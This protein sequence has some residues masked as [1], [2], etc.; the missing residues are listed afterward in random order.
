MNTCYN[1][2]IKKSTAC[3][4]AGTQDFPNISADQ[5]FQ[6][7]IYANIF[8]V[9]FE[10]TQNRIYAGAQDAWGKGCANPLVRSVT[11]VIIIIMVIS[12]IVSYYIMLCY[13]CECNACIMSAHASLSVL[14]ALAHVALRAT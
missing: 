2:K 5:V 4:A 11:S 12:Y 3:H 10:Y 8:Q 14:R 9:F 7:S 13:I 1:N 6:K